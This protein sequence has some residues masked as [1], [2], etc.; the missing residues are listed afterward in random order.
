MLFAQ[1]PNEQTIYCDCEHILTETNLKFI[2]DANGCY[3]LRISVTPCA[4]KYISSIRIEFENGIP[5]CLK[6]TGNIFR[7]GVLASSYDLNANNYLDFPLETP[8]NY[9]NGFDRKFK[10]CPNNS[11]SCPTDFEYTVKV[12]V[13]FSDGS[14]CS[15]NMNLWTR[16]QGPCHCFDLIE[17]AQKDGDTFEIERGKL[18]CDNLNCFN[19]NFKITNCREVGIAGFL[20]NFPKPNCLNGIYHVFSPNCNTYVASAD[21]TLYEPIPVIFQTPVQPFTNTT[22]KTYIICSPNNDCPDGAEYEIEIEVRFTNDT[23]CIFHEIV[24][25]PAL[26]INYQ[27]KN[28][29]DFV[30]YPNPT[31]SSNKIQI[32]NVENYIGSEILIFDVKGTNVFQGLISQN[33]IELNNEIPAGK[34][35]ISVKKGSIIYTTNIIINK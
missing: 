27:I 31:N 8:I 28:T 5:D 32:T 7:Q 15:K 34:Y 25:I 6:P 11:I 22:E 21:L 30:V 33:F 20:I 14:S 10:I 1:D 4:A 17:S 26:S 12:T 16:L 23:Y 13:M 24:K 9:G 29:V 18:I 19:I 3:E 35:M 2:P